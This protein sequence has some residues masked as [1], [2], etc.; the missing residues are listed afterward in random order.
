MNR[1]FVAVLIAAVV[2]VVSLVAVQSFGHQP[3]HVVTS[4]RGVRPSPEPNT[5][6]FVSQHV[7]PGVE[8]PLPAPL[9]SPN[10]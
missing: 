4:V 10:G 3:S 8:K 7:F 5:R 2:A 6:P 9:P 1:V